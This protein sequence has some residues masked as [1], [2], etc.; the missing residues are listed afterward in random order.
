MMHLPA[1][2]AGAMLAL[3]SSA[4][5]PSAHAQNVPPIQQTA[6]AR[7][8][9]V[10]PVV[11]VSGDSVDRLRLGGNAE[12]AGLMLRSLSSLTDPHRAGRAARPFALVLPT[13]HVVTNSELPFGQNDGAMWAGKG[14]SSRLLLGFAATAGPLR[15]V[16][17]P[18]IVRSSNGDLSID[19]NDPAFAPAIPPSRSL[20][21]SASN[22]HPYSIDLPWRM[23]DASFSEI[24]PGQS[25]I[26]LAARGVEAGAATENEWWGPALRNPIVMGDNAAGFPHLFL[27]T[28]GP[29]ATPLGRF[30]AR[31][32]VGGLEE[33][34]WFDNDDTNDVRSAPSPSHGARASHRLSFSGLRDRS[35]R[36]R[37]TMA[38]RLSGGSTRS[39]T[40][41]IR[42]PGH[43]PTRQCP[44]AQTRYSRFSAARHFR[45]TVSTR[46]SSGEERTS[47]FRFATFWRSRFIRADTRLARSG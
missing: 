11:T 41:G 44:R 17:I 35:S 21:S 22:V 19:P 27:R 10:A 14:V 42:T 6:A 32:I 13:L 25:S 15:L 43:S 46:T 2:L 31:W 16:V 39:P 45:H 9:A 24:H 3:A 23:G 26:T 38:R 36:P 40:L 7:E 4:M 30:D 29:V 1:C 33:S 37:R 47:R 5:A 34:D 20:F 12:P 18:E 28:R 8:S